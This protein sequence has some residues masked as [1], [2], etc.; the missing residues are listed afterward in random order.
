VAVSPVWLDYLVS[1]CRVHPETPTVRRPTVWKRSQARRRIRAFVAI[2]DTRVVGRE[3]E[4]AL[5]R[6]LLSVYG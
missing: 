4:L 3:D 6:G 2:S 1:G 5:L